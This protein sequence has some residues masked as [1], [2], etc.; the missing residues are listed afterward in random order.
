MITF[1]DDDGKALVVCIVFAL[2]FRCGIEDPIDVC[3]MSLVQE[4]S[5]N[6]GRFFDELFKVVFIIVFLGAK[7]PLELAHLSQL[8]S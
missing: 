7:A 5:F 6:V 4:M 3:K 8:V 2:Y 1:L